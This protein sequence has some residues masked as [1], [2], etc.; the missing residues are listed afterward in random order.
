MHLV[1][2]SGGWH[3]SSFERGGSI[4]KGGHVSSL[5]RGGPLASGVHWHGG[6]VV[7]TKV[8]QDLEYFLHQRVDAIVKN[9]KKR[10]GGGERPYGTPCTEA[11]NQCVGTRERKLCI[12]VLVVTP[13][14]EAPELGTY[15]FAGD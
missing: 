13:A 7:P 1:K 3:V 6:A 2:K 4:S 14:S 10:G 11:V 8:A 9:K 12:S 5:E 15:S